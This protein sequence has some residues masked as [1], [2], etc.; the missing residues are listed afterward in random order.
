MQDKIPRPSVKNYIRSGDFTL[1][2]NAYRKL[3]KEELLVIG[4]KWVSLKGLKAWPTS[5]HAEIDA[6]AGFD[7]E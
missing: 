6:I 4:A 1:V 3:S 2:V 5:G 7:E